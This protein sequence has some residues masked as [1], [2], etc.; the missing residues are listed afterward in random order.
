MKIKYVIDNYY[1]GCIRNRQVY[2]WRENYPVSIVDVVTGRIIREV[3]LGSHL[4]VNASEPFHFF[5]GAIECGGVDLQI[6]PTGRY[7]LV[8]NAHRNPAY[9]LHDLVANSRVE[10][11]FLMVGGARISCNAF[12]P[13]GKII[14]MHNSTE[15][16]DKVTFNFYNIASGRQILSVVAGFMSLKYKDY[17]QS[18]HFFGVQRYKYPCVFGFDFDQNYNFNVIYARYSDPCLD[19]VRL[20]NFCNKSLSE[21]YAVVDYPRGGMFTV[22]CRKRVL[23]VIPSF[24][25]GVNLMRYCTAFSNQDSFFAHLPEDSTGKN[26]DIVEIR[27]LPNL[28]VISRLEVQKSRKRDVSLVGFSPSDEI[29]L[30]GSEGGIHA[31]CW[32]ESTKRHL[33]PGQIGGQSDEHVNAREI[34]MSMNI[35]PRSISGIWTYGWALDIHT[36]YSIPIDP[37][38]HVFDTKR[39]EMGEAIYKLKYR[40]DKTQIDPIAETIAEFINKKAE[41][42]DIVAIL[43]VPPSNTTRPFQPVPAIAA[44]V[45]KILN[46]PFVTDYLLKIKQTT[47][48]KGMSDAQKRHEELEGAFAVA[49]DRF[50]GK[51]L[52]LIDDLF[53]S[54]E[55]LNAVSNVLISGGKIAKISVITATITRSRR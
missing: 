32:Q 31:I 28:D 22:L 16:S 47:P 5:G 3:D 34:D 39:S 24:T 14:C 52:L 54:G 51:H 21:S 50:T 25:S 37:D 7:V 43:A 38:N 44:A 4:S 15:F 27:K 18:E 49:D 19:I 48:L 36:L 11:D 8:Y 26:L 2:C 20:S 33:L 29:F 13:D 45:G 6:D 23:G 35:N 12:S 10:R 46:L 40:G 53:R 42:S 55:T 30:Y 1:F 9:Y 41:L 17:E